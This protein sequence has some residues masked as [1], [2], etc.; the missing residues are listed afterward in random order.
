MI[1]SF[2]CLIFL[3]LCTWLYAKTGDA[4]NNGVIDILDALKIAQYAV[5]LRMSPF[6]TT[7]ADANGNGAIDIIDAL[8]VAQYSVSMITYFPTDTY[9]LLPVPRMPQYTDT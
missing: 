9:K 7:A 3:L 5:G 2:L 6:N 1:K 4:D 8:L